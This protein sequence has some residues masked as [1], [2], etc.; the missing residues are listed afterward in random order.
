MWTINI[1]G[2]V[3]LNCQFSIIHFK[4]SVIWMDLLQILLEIL[5]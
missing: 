2:Y 3:I 1:A 4:I 5:Y